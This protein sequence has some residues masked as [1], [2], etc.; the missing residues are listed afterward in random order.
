MAHSSLLMCAINGDASYSRRPP[1]YNCGFFSRKIHPQDRLCSNPFHTCK[2]LSTIA[3]SS[4]MLVHERAGLLHSDILI[5]CIGLQSGD[6]ARILMRSVQRWVFLFLSW[7][8]SN[9]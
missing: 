6:L 4:G 8:A 3:T 7:S 5:V 9:F 2:S 1:N